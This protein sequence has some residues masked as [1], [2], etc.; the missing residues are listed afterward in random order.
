MTADVSRETSAAIDVV[1]GDR[2]PQAEQYVDW[3]ADQGV[4]RGL[5][6]PREAPR[7]WERHVLNCAVVAELLPREATLR[8][9]GSGAGLPGI[10]LALARPDL[11]IEL[12]EPLQRRAEFLTET[13]ARLGLDTVTVTRARAEELRG[14]QPVRIVTARAV[15][16][17]LRLA[18]WCLPLLAPG[19]SLVA[20]KGS[21]VADELAAAADRLPALGAASWGIS[22]H[23]TGLLA[24]PTTVVSVVRGARPDG[25]DRPG[26]GRRTARQRGRR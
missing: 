6:G 16:P 10:P 19:G 2:R 24:Q 5:I 15:A 12:V 14:A 21:R 3:L 7:L 23:G 25:G 26:A 18:E 17:L 13:C 4:L 11:R 1:F 8:D 20:L 9:V 22:Q